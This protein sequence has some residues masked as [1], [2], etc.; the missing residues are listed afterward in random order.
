MVVVVWGGGFNV[1]VW[2]PFFTLKQCHNV[3]T[4]HKSQHIDCYSMFGTSLKTVPTLPQIHLQG[5]KV[6]NITF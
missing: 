2:L 4:L 1:F 5:L 3:K 6:K